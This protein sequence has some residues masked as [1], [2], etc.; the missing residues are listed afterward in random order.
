MELSCLLVEKKKKRIL[1][2]FVFRIDRG[3]TFSVEV[4]RSPASFGVF[5]SLIFLLLEEGS[6]L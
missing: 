6:D 1:G 2:N 5:W 4:L 3:F